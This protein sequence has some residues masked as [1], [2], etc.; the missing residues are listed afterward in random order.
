MTIDVDEK[1]LLEMNIKDMQLV[2]VS[3]GA[4]RTPK[5]QDGSLP[6]SSLPIPDRA[7][8]PQHLLTQEPNFSHLFTLLEQLS[9]M[10]SQV[11]QMS[12]VREII[13]EFTFS[14]L[15]QSH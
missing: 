4:S 11:A 7:K 10:K 2:F 15:L 5:R 8:I 9:S 6:S 13:S 14:L 12:L 3:V 1:T